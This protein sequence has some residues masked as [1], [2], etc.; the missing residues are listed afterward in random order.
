[1]T[2][3][4]ILDNPYILQFSFIPPQF[5]ERTIVTNDIV[6]NFIMKTPTYRGI[7][8]TGVRGS[9]KTVILG[10]IRNRINAYDEW[11]TIDLNP[12]S[13]LLDSLSNSVKVDEIRAALNMTS[14]TFTTYRK[15]LIESGIVGAR[16]YG[17]LNFRLPRFEN[18]VKMRFD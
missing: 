2:K 1:M 18:F 11:I 17:Y 13:N 3:F 4:N 8:I 10:D 6:N 9:G 7:F 14:N 12:E 5:I 15:R 16:Q